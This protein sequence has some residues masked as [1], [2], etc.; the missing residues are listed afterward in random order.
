MA[1]SSP[2]Y[3]IGV[4]Q[5][6]GSN[7]YCLTGIMPGFS[8]G[9][10]SSGSLHTAVAGLED[11]LTRVTGKPWYY[12][13]VV[14]SAGNDMSAQNFSSINN[15]PQ[16]VVITFPM[17]P[18]VPGNFAASGTVSQGNA[19][20][21]DTAVHN[22]FVSLIAQPWFNPEKVSVRIGWECN[23][24]GFPW[25]F[26]VVDHNTT[27]ANGVAN[28]QSLFNRHVATA[29]AAGYT[30]YFE[31]NAGTN[32]NTKVPIAT[33]APTTTDTRVIYGFDAYNSIGFNKADY[34]SNWNTYQKPNLDAI[35]NFCR[36][37]GMMA[38]MSESGMV[39]RSDNNFS[40]NDTPLYYQLM[41][42][43]VAANADVW[44][45]WVFYNQDGHNGSNV[46]ELDQF[47]YAVTGTN[48]SPGPI[49]GSPDTVVGTGSTA[50]N[51]SMGTL[52][53]T[54]STGVAWADTTSVNKPFGLAAYKA[55]CVAGN[56][57]LPNPVAPP[58]QVVP[59]STNTAYN[60]FAPFG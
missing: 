19:G 40:S 38:G 30:G 22:Y 32:D 37:H 10:G 49:G 36:S 39:Y 55:G 1:I 12:E 26:T 14:I 25:G 23:G 54:S 44:A 42:A 27:V 6:N 18:F 17:M 43:Y 56:L 34:L 24:T 3:R 11:H 15:C 16:F 9:L 52:A 58:A 50:T 7:Q 21:Y 31:F 59:S 51:A 60:F 28:V 53:N 8:V 5:P 48:A 47:F 2:Q 35:T 20:A 57:Q 46:S 4:S 33:Y 45:Y 41:S 13:C 29:R